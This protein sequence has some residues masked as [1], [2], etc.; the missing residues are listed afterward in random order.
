VS[1]HHAPLID[2][3]RLRSNQ[4]RKLRSIVL[5]LATL[6]C[7]YGR[8]FRE[9]GVRV[10]GMN[11]L[12]DFVK[13]VPFTTK[14]QIQEDRDAHPPFGTNL[15]RA[16][17]Q[18]TR[19]CQTSGTTTGRPMAWIDT[20]ESWEAMLACWRRVYEA[21]GLV[22]GRDRI[23]F[24]FSFGPFL[25]FWT[26]FEAA[27]K[28]FLVIPC[29]GLSSQARLEVM[30]RYGATVLCCTPTYALRLGELIGEASGVER[31][32][33]RIQKLI[34]AG[35]SGGSVP[36]LRQR[37]EKLWD[38]QIFDHHGMTEVGPVSFETPDLPRHLTVIEEA[39]FAEVVDPVTGIEV[40][41]GEHGELVLSTLDRTACPLLRYRTGDYVRKRLHRGRLALEGGILSRIDDMVVLRGVNV[42]PSAV[43]AVVREFPEVIEFMVEQKKIDD[44]DEIELLVET[45]P[46]IAKS[47][48]KKLE[49]RLR[50]TFS[51]R[52]PVRLVDGGT[53]P[54]HEF[55]A[56]RWRL[57]EAA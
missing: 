54:R 14:A 11:R 9:T 18:Y 44:M 12:E 30:A 20:P 7:F 21:A 33:L 42:Y 23:C 6:D 15:T 36:A 45:D 24:A 41:D 55:K 27:S 10:S 26:A 52:I 4:W 43:E 38:A 49:S 29:G 28:D 35:E 16:I 17:S 56:R 32:S 53:L 25:G 50:D 22:K 1:D 46:N 5:N 57:A 13:Q 48:L 39:Y 37:L 19:F 40:E 47:L 34:V 3:V 8:R 2:R 31:M 51:L